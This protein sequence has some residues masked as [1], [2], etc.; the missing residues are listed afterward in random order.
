MPHPFD[1]TATNNTM[2]YETTYNPKRLLELAV[3]EAYGLLE[4]IESDLFNR[5]FH[6]APAAIQ[7]EIKLLQEDLA[8][9][10]S[11]LRTDMPPL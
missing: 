5:S 1:E 3:L 11:L 4:P 8:L 10:A 6:D 9:D 2:T 7:D